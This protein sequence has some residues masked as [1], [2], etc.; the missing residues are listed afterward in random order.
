MR[1]H[2][3]DHLEIK[4][5]MT[6]VTPA[7]INRFQA[8]YI[9]ILQRFRLLYYIVFYHCHFLFTTYFHH[10]ITIFTELWSLILIF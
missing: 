6:I 5:F 2:F 4:H 7:M 10:H 8:F 1:T 9:F 3:N